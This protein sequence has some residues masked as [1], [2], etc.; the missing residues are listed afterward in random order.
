[1]RWAVSMTRGGQAGGGTECSERSKKK[2][3]ATHPPIHAQCGTGCAG[4]RRDAHRGRVRG[5]VSLV[6]G[7][8][9]Q[10]LSPSL[11]QEYRWQKLWASAHH[12][13]KVS[14]AP[15]PRASPTNREIGDGE[16][17]AGTPPALLY[18]M[19]ADCTRRERTCE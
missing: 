19:A 7:F 13:K 16:N 10:S 9:L 1:M 6:C 14:R 5:N 17:A 3:K 4:L 18:T 11:P 12:R 8:N 2:K 15:E